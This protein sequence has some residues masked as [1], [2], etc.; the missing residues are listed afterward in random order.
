MDFLRLGVITGLN[1]IPK[2]HAYA[3]HSCRVGCDC[4]MRADCKGRIKQGV[5]G[6]EDQLVLRCGNQQV[7]HKFEITRA[8]LDADNARQTGHDSHQELRAEIIPR[9]DIVDDDR[10]I[11]FLG[12][13]LEMR[14]GRILVGLEDIVNR[15]DLQ[16]GH[17][18]FSNGL[19]FLRSVAGAV[20]DDACD[21]RNA[22][23]DLLGG[24]FDRAGQFLRGERVAFAGAATEADA[25]HLLAQHEADILAQ[26]GLVHGFIVLEGRDERR[27]DTSECL[28]HFSFL[29][30]YW[31]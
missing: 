2:G 13:P 19:G 8:L 15:G 14:V 24:D 29:R 20:G 26:S 5:D 12:Q 10:N 23:I 21:D 7:G 22:A 9:N 16:R 4:A 28:G 11:G 18:E 1:R 3:W 6:G 25:V 31:A 27:N 30:C 17:F